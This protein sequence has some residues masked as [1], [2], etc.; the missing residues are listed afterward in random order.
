V[1]ALEYLLMVL[2]VGVAVVGLL[3]A[4]RFYLLDLTAVRRLAA[5]YRGAYETLLNKYWVDEIYDRLFVGPFVRGS[6]WLWRRVDAG[7]IDGAVN[8]VGVTLTGG[9]TALRLVQSGQAQSYAFYTMLGV[10]AVL[11]YVVTR[12]RG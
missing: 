8:G 3:I 5:R 1:L 4:Y 10:L 6:N 12:G 7:A 9:A 2:S 11:L